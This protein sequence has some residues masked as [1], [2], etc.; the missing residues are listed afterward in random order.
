MLPEDPF[1]LRDR[2][3][4]GI[5]WSPGAYQVGVY[6]EPLTGGVTVYSS[7]WKT[8]TILKPM[9]DMTSKRGIT[10]GGAVGG[11]GGKL[12]PWGGSVVLTEAD[13]LHGSPPTPN[14]RS[15][16]RTTCSTSWRCR[17]ARRS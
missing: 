17:R 11:A 8:F 10:I 2:I 12:V 6:C 14:A 3:R 5:A 4:H 15:T 1:L 9:P 13:A 16:S 7:G